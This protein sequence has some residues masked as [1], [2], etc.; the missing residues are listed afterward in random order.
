MAQTLVTASNL[1]PVIQIVN[2]FLLTTSISGVIARGLTKANII[3]SIDLD[4]ALV[5]I[6]LVRTTRAWAAPVKSRNA[7]NVIIS[8]SSALANQLQ[9]RYRLPM[10]LGNPLC[11]SAYSK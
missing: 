8:S 10:A 6:A 9:S 11:L 7:Y 2:W 5:S 4:D 3:R 1:T